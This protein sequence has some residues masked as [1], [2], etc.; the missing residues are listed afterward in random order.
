MKLAYKAFEDGLICRGYRFTFPGINTTEKANCRQNGFHCAENPFDC[1]KYYPN[2]KGTVFAIVSAGGDL[3]EDDI[4]SKITCT[5]ME[6]KKLLSTQDFFLHCL[7][8]YAN[9]LGRSYP[10]IKPERGVAQNGYTIVAGR[11]PLAKGKRGDYICMIKQVTPDTMPT[12]FAIL[13]I[14][15]RTYHADTFY[16]V[17]G[18]EREDDAEEA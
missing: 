13:H 4:D 15:G 6:I 16:D 3:D 12:N 10:A 7:K 8:Y 1:L 18:K 17:Y 14:D 5:E 2:I 9:H 11:D